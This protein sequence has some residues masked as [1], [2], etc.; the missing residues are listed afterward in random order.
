M[1]KHKIA[2]F[3][4]KE[5][6]K[7]IYNDEWWFVINDIIFALMDSKYPAQY[8]KRIKARD[9]ELKKLI[10]QGGVQLNWK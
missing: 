5:I 2:I 10:E 9:N 1:E 3:Q 7:T 8:F 4:K 6:R